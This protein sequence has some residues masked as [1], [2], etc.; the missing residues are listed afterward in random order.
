MRRL[1]YL[2]SVKRDLLDILAYLAEE[3]GSVT[4]AQGFVAQLRSRCRALASKPGTL[5]RA[6]NC[7]P[8]SEAS[9]TRATSFSSAMSRIGLRW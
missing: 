9:P 4:V 6:L 5:G 8:K 7:I 3:S 1:I 2:A